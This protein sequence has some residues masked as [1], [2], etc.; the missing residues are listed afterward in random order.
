M[1]KNLLLISIFILS[2]FNIYSQKSDDLGNGIENGVIMSESDKTIVSGT[3]NLNTVTQSSK[4]V[5]TIFAQHDLITHTGGGFGGADASVLQTSLS[6][7]TLGGGFS[8]A[9]GYSLADDFIIPAGETWRI[10]G[11]TFYAY[12]TGSTT[13]STITDALI[14][15]YSGAPNAGGT[16]VQDFWAGS[17]MTSTAWTNI[18]RTQES[19]ITTA[20]TRPIMNVE[21]TVTEFDLT[22]GE[23]WVEVSLSGSLASGPWCPPITILGQTTTGNA[24]QYNTSWTNFNDS[25]TL[26]QQGVPFDIIGEVI[27]EGSAP[28]TFVVDNTANT[29]FTGFALK[30]SWDAGGNYDAA[31]MG[32]AE[33]SDFYDDGTHGDVTSGDDIWTVTVNLIPDGGTNTWEWGVNDQDDNW[34][35]GNFQ[36]TIPDETP[37]T[38]TYATVGIKD[39]LGAFTI[40]PNPSNGLFNINVENTMTLEVYDIT[41]KI[42]HTQLLNGASSLQINDAGM[43]FIRFTNEEGSSV[44]KVVV[45]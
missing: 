9:T 3:E 4:A 21:C 6:M 7:N 12:Q 29:G 24:I 22:E 28:I 25:G 15:V 14:R 34:I 11:F 13:T 36:F 44:Q 41:G 30:G 8:T 1:M 17:N 33:H 45:K 20:T 43:Y 26:T 32:G 18:Y 40:F 37:Q 39:L 5:S 19:D 35:D 2:F 31:W 27:A 42:I 23:Y 16:V 10:S 38:L